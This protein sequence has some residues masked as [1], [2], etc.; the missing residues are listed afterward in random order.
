MGPGTQKSEVGLCWG[1][2][3]QSVIQMAWKSFHKPSTVLFPSRLSPY[4]EG[5]A[6]I[7]ITSQG[8]KYPCRRNLALQPWWWGS[9]E[10]NGSVIGDGS[11]LCSLLN[12]KAPPR[13][14]SWRTASPSLPPQV[15]SLSPTDIHVPTVGCHFL[16]QGIFLTQ[17]WKLHLLH[18]Q[19]DS[20]VSSLPLSH[21]GR[22]L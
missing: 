15:R 6:W 18:W 11:S 19:A 10:R 16:L 12:S 21:R 17:G 22:P 2:F 8:K 9:R 20:S 3:P 5:R 7:P 1:A 4:K 14:P 13:T